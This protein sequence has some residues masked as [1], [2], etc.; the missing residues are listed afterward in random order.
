MPRTLV[1]HHFRR[2]ATEQA[3]AD[4]TWS[5]FAYVALVVM[6]EALRLQQSREINPRRRQALSRNESED[7]GRMGTQQGRPRDSR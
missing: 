2:D 4:F 6:V 1:D 5:G 3:L 7:A